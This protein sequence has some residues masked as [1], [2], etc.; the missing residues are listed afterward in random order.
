M[1]LKQQLIQTILHI[2]KSIFHPQ[3]TNLYEAN[4]R[5]ILSFG[6]QV[7]PLLQEIGF[8]LENTIKETISI[9]PPWTHTP[10]NTN[11]EMSKLKKSDTSEDIYIS[12][13]LEIK[14][15]YHNYQHIYTD[16]SKTDDAVSAAA[17]TANRCL[18]EAHNKDSSIYSA[19]LRAIEL[20]LNHISNSRH[21][22][23]VVFS[24]SK[25]SLQALQNLWSNHPLVCR[26]LN[27]HSLLCRLNKNIVFCWLPSHV[28]IRG[29]RVIPFQ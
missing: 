23:F 4:E 22:N 27:L 17:V 6:L 21:N 24:D 11:F 25:S 29:N 3:L 28:G 8:E 14:E 1:P 19:E 12:K 9:T 16:G 20:A 13:F 2:Y 7:K 5:N 18:K 10:L 15:K 26:V